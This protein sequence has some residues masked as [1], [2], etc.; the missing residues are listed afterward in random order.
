MGPRKPNAKAEA[1]RQKKAEHQAGVDARSAAAAEREAAAE[2]ARGSD[3]RGAARAEADQRRQA[4]ADR[5]R[6]EKAELLAAD[7]AATG[8]P[9][10]LKRDVGAGMKAKKGRG[11]K[12]NDLDLL[13]E[14]LV[15][16]AEKKSRHQKKAERDKKERLKKEEEARQRRL[17]AEAGDVDPLL[18]NTNSMIGE[19]GM[20]GRA[21]NLASAE[22]NEASG[23]D[24]AISALNVSGDGAP[25]EHPEKR[26]K[27]LHMAF[28]ERMM[29]EMKEQYPGLRKSQYKEKIF[30]LWKKSAENPMNRIGA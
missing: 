16:D 6:R 21:A 25:Y 13:S 30:Q 26:M 27:A 12:K 11:K 5:K 14:A 20:A 22:A 3:Q 19:D 4:D 17:A 1:A 24:G 2:W 15:G 23:I 18:A 28:E 29:P 7:E 10:K 8:G 9:T